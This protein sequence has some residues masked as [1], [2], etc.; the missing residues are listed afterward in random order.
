MTL[1]MATTSTPAVAKEREDADMR[2]LLPSEL[3]SHAR[4]PSPIGGPHHAASQR[5]HNVARACDRPNGPT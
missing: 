2:V 4:F 3:G 1:A 5:R